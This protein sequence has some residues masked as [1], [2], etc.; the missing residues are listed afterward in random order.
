MQLCVEVEDEF[1]ADS[2]ERTAAMIQ[3]IGA[4]NL[5]VNWDPGNAWAA[6]ERPYPDGYQAVRGR[7]GHVH[8]KDVARTGA[9]A[10][11]YVVDGEIDWPGQM[12]A[13]QADGYAG[14]I[15]VEPHMQPKVAS[16]RAVLQRLK[17]L[18]AEGVQEEIGI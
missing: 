2:G 18:I 17:N 13:L 6:G 12:R 7:V 15:S 3:A 9:G 10:Y 11:A 16:A 8:F 4:P 5:W 14:Y 1:W